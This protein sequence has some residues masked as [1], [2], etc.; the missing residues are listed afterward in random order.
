MIIRNLDKDKLFFTSDLHAH[1]SGIIQYC[2]RPFQSV[3]EMDETLIINWNN[4]VPKDGIV[5]VLGDFAMTS[6][7][8]YIKSFVEKLNGT[9]YLIYGNHDYQN[10]LDRQV[11]KDI[12]GNR[13]MDV[14]ELIIKDSE[15][16]SG[17]CNLFISH[18]PHMYWR[19]GSFH[20]HGHVHSGPAT[21][22]SEKVPFHPMRYD[23]GVDNNDFTPVSYEQIKIIFTK[24]SLK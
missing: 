14:A 2:N 4:V 6:Q 19:K 23:V 24:Y 10:R 18:Y 8:N 12:F 17:H 11:I 1:H 22:T 5:F 3:E 9:I 15:L 21:D 20:L 16:E 13:V 7:I